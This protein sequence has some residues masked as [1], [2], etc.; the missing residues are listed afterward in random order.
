VRPAEP[1]AQRLLVWSAAGLRL[2][3]DA[4]RSHYY[5]QPWGREV[6]AWFEPRELGGRYRAEVGTFGTIE[7]AK[8][9]C[10]R[11]L[12]QRLRREPGARPIDVRIASRW[13]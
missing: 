7:R 5:V 6:L 13:R 4:A 10:E 8:A 9:A 12:T 2:V 3:A 1:W 11:D